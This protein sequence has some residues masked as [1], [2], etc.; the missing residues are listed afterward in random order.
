[1]PLTVATPAELVLHVPAGV[2]S[3][4]EAVAP[5]HM[6]TGVA[7]VIAAGLAATVT[8]AVTEHPPT[9][10]V[11]TEVP[12]AIAFTRPVREPTVATLVV[13]EVHVPPP[14]SV[15]AVVPPTHTFNEPVIAAGGALTVTGIVEKQPSLSVYDIVVVPVPTP[16]TEPEDEP[17]VAAAVLLLAHVPPPGEH[18][19]ELEAPTHEIDDPLIAPGA[20]FTVIALNTNA[21]PQA[22]VTV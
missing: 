10:Y 21:L 6:L 9:A 18:V 5:T 12:G 2:T 7:G 16:V 14:P 13:P 19:S 4:S 11:I 15:N 22:F 8:V 3:P 1:M 17:I 20:I